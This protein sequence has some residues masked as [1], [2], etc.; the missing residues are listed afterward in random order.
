MTTKT[1]KIL[2]SVQD[3]KDTVKHIGT[4]AAIAM[5]DAKWHEGKT[6]REIAEHQMEV[7]E[8]CVPFAIFHE[9]VEKTIG[10]P[11]F[12]HEFGL[13]PHLLWNEIFHASTGLTLTESMNLTP[14]GKRLI[15]E[16]GG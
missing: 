4:D 10:R 12:A 3:F 2:L 15:L 16:I 7:A 5:Y 14:E 8:L 1:R 11:V 9:A 6:H 13:T